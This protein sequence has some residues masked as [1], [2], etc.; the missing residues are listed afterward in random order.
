MINL[1]LNSSSYNKRYVWTRKFRA[2]IELVMR[3]GHNFFTLNLVVQ[4]FFITLKTVQLEP[5]AKRKTKLYKH[6][7]PPMFYK[8]N[9]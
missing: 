4:V 1:L 6:Q 7:T 2:K 9:Q 3:A 8:S 5:F